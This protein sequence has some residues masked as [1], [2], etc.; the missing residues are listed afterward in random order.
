MRIEKIQIDVIERDTGPLNVKDERSDIGGKTTQAVLRLIT[1]EGIEGNAF[2]GDQATSSEDRI[3]II[4]DVLKPKV[5]GMDTNH[6]E[7]LWSEVDNLSGHGLP[8]YSSWAPVDV[9][10]WDIAGK[11]VGKSISSLLGGRD[12]EINLYATYPPRHNDPIGFIKEAEELLE[13]GYSAYKIHPGNLSVQDTILVV[14]GVRK[15]VGDKMELMLDRNHGYSVSEA[16]KVGKALDSNNYYWFEDPLIASDI[17]GIKRLHETLDTPINMSDSATF[18]IKEAA[19]FLSSNLVGM[20]RGTTRK[21]G[22]TG[23]IKLSAMADA[24]N[25]NCEIGLAGNSIMNIANLHVISSV[26][27]NS[28][29]EYWRPEHIHQW[30]IEKEIKINQNGKLN[31]P[32]NPGLGIDLD[33]DWISF[34]KIHVLD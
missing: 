6:R 2:V 7:W 33:E 21:L 10:L 26:S 29:Y 11:E 12:K 18:L 15:V 5:L 4:N 22:I 16:L 9:A 14:E 31:L 20:I 34:H 30:G 28:F 13:E 3:K 27:N 17:R 25:I 19:N 23:L 24:F 8:I 1:D 32:K